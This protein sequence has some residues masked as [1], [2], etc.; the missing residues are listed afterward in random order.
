[1]NQYIRGNMKQFHLKKISK[2]TRI[3]YQI[4]YESALNEQQ[5]SAVT[6]QSKRLLILAGAGTGKTKTL[7]YKV[8]RLIENGI[9]PE[10]IVLLTFTRRA[11]KEM[12]DRATILL[13]ERCQHIQGGTFHSFCTQILRKYSGHI[14][15]N[16]EFSILDSSD[17]MDLIQHVR[18]SLNIEHRTQR[19]PAKRSLAKLFSLHINKQLDIRVLL[20]AHYPQFLVHEKEI[21]EL[22]K[23]YESYKAKHHIMDFDDLLFNTEKLFVEHPDILE[24]ISSTCKHVLVDEFQDTNKIQA[25][26]CEHFSSF[27]QNLTVVG[28]DAQSIYAFRGSD[29]EN[30]LRFPNEF[31]DTELI[32]LEENYRSSPEILDVANAI[33]KQSSKL[34]DKKLF[35]NR[36]SS[37]LPAL[38]K[39]I[40]DKEEAEFIAQLVLHLREHQIDLDQIAILFRNA[41]DSFT[42]E[43]ALQSKNVPFKKFGG[44]KFTEAAHI[45]DVLAHVRVLNNPNDTVAWQRVLMLIEGVGPKT[46]E[47]LFLWIQQVQ[48]KKESKASVDTTNWFSNSEWMNKSY[49]NGLNKLGKCL[50]ESSKSNNWY[51]CIPLIIDYYVPICK[52]LYDDAPKRE[53][54]LAAIHQIAKSYHDVQSFLTDLVLDPIT[55]TVIDTLESK[56]EESPLSLSTIHS[57][58]G[59]EWKH[60][61]IMQCLDGSIPSTFS[62]DQDDL[63]DEELRLLYVAATR[64]QD[65][66]YFTYP[67]TS[68]RHR[69]GD[70]LT[71]ASRFLDP[72][73]SKL[74]PWELIHDNESQDDASL[75]E[76]V[77]PPQL[78]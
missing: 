69:E 44:Q 51:D 77:N 12:M 5:F 16:Q 66:L 40:D 49:Y 33:L 17:S 39:A 19:F 15:Y 71:K 23:D 78:E 26:L 72:I 59:L 41:R 2:S 52:D 47:D 55:D 27:H 3:D 67:R 58:K 18:S 31:A 53:E 75:T 63:L 22:F 21:I 10:Q 38:I 25:I 57:A 24:R 64:A 48:S 29:H 28:D 74:E 45:K 1:M 14:G 37:D 13:D 20:Q 54:D 68:Y 8:A 4:E 7:V 50:V 60:V 11:A 42:L 34:F 61:I 35:T 56:D 36:E 62:L 9:P 43:L 32:K 73:T 30:I 65:M 46:A 6:S 76:G 70:Y